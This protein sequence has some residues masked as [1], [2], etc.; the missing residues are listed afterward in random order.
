MS[1]VVGL[2]PSLTNCGIA[3]LEGEP[4]A[5]NIH[6]SVASL[7]CVGHPG[8]DSDGW[9]ERSDRVVSQTRLVLSRVPPD[10]ALVVIEAMPYMRKPLPSYGDR[11]ALWWGIYSSLRARRTP[12]AVCHQATRAA[13]A[14]G[15]G[16]APK[17][18]VLAAVR[19]MWPHAGLRPRNDDNRADALVVASMGALHLDWR[20]PFE[21]KPRHHTGLKSVAW[22]TPEMNS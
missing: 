19:E 5:N 14:T 3:V 16:N 4:A 21:I 1:A 9:D 7:L 6:A 10:A 17:D 13:W 22:P 20:L 8:K 15:K 11:W 2:D 18:D 12:I